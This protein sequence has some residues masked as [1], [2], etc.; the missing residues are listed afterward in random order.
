MISGRRAKKRALGVTCLRAP[1]LRGPQTGC[2]LGRSLPKGEMSVHRSD[3]PGFHE[4]GSSVSVGTGAGKVAV[5]TGSRTGDSAHRER[6][7]EH[8]QF[9]LDTSRKRKRRQ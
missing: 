8:G 5:T 2:V 3:V 6:D 7:T 9:L 4:S 1:V